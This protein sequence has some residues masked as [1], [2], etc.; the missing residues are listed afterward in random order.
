[1]S[2]S[3]MTR[4]AN[5]T[6]AG[7]IALVLPVSLDGETWHQVVFEGESAAYVDRQAASYVVTHRDRVHIGI[8]ER[9]DWSRFPTTFN[10]LCSDI[11]VC[12]VEY[13]QA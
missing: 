7:L 2:A 13:A 6:D 1:M 11:Q 9:A 10:A 4:T 12:A 8:D 3:T 5:R